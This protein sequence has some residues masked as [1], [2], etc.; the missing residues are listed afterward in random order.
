MKTY[1]SPAQAAT[2]KVY[3]SSDDLQEFLNGDGVE[4][5]Y[6]QT[7]LY[8]LEVSIPGDAIYNVRKNN[9]VFKVGLTRMY[10]KRHSYGI[11]KERKK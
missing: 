4:A 8:K 1:F 10:G 3:I 7:F 6:Y 2:V 11:R 5:S 9:N